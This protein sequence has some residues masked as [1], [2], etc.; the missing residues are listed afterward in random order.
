MRNYFAAP[1]GGA[2]YARGRPDVHTAIIGTASPDHLAANVAAAAKGP[3][4]P[5][6]YDEAVQRLP[7]VL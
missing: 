4:D 6:V 2:R 3:L 5:E 1:W 7:I